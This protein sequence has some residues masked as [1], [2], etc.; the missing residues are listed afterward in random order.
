MCTAVS[1]LLSRLYA[2]DVRAYQFIQLLSDTT[3]PAVHLFCINSNE[4]VLFLSVA[5]GRIYIFYYLTNLIIFIVTILR[6][7]MSMVGQ[8]MTAIVYVACVKS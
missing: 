3:T 8:L 2:N 5:Y 6:I 4:T 7:N 1:D